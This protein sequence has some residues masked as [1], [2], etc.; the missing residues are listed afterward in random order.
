[1]H[2]R[3]RKAAACGP[4]S[5]IARVGMPSPRIDPYI[6]CRF[7]QS[8]CRRICFS[9][10]SLVTYWLAMISPS[11]A[12]ASLRLR[13]A[14][15]VDL[16]RCRCGVIATVLSPVVIRL[17]RLIGYLAVGRAGGAQM[18]RMTRLIRSF[19]IP[20]SSAYEKENER[21]RPGCQNRR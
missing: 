20:C 16:P 7:L 4:A 11:A 10:I 17:I 1:L 13:S 21:L 6:F 9:A 8:S 2:T 19:P 5:E 3:Q 18:I 12:P 15:P 14:L